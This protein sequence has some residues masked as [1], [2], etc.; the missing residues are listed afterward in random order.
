MTSINRRGARNRVLSR[1]GRLPELPAARTDPGSRCRG[2][3]WRLSLVNSYSHAV[4]T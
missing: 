1:H 4:D 2:R 3:A